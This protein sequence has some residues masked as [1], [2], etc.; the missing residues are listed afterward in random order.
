MNRLVFTNLSGSST[1]TVY[2]ADERG[3]NETLLGTITPP[4]PPEVDFMPPAIFNG[5]EKL[6]VI[7]VDD[8][9][10]RYYNLINCSYN[11][12][13]SIIIVEN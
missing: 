6:L 1:Y 8:L 5:V 4:V 10:K 9:N 3:D 13:F 2:V 12:V 11:C 7:L